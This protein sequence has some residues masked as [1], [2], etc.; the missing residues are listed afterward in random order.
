[1]KVKTSITISDYLLHE[2]DENLDTCKNRSNFIEIAVE[3]Y[4]KELIRE[5]R[6][7]EDLEIISN[8][9]DYFNHEAEDSLFFQE[10]I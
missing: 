9:A 10:E 4:L 3:H 8:N 5:K 7:K 6:N 2:I 1:M